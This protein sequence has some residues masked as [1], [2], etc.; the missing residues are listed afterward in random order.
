[1]IGTHP[2]AQSA[3]RGEREAKRKINIYKVQSAESA[4]HMIK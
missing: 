2:R 4:D 1:M 3:E